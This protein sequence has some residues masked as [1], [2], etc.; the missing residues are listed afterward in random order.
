ML[1]ADVIIHVNHYLCN[2]SF[3][4]YAILGQPAAILTAIIPLVNVSQLYL[5]C[6]YHIHVPFKNVKYHRDKLRIS[7]HSVIDYECYDICC[8][9]CLQVLLFSQIRLRMEYRR[10]TRCEWKSSC[11]KMLERNFVIYWK[12]DS[13]QM[14]RLQCPIN[15]GFQLYILLQI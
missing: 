11:K 6:Q 14:N 12:V 10:K 15:V 8:C 1:K 4:S 5:A 7:W 2:I 13:I 9:F 3:S